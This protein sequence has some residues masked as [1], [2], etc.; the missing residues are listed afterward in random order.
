MKSWQNN[1]RFFSA[2]V[3]LFFFMERGMNTGSWLDMGMFL[4]NVMIAAV[5]LGLASCPQASVADYPDVVR[6]I[7]QIPQDHLVICGMSL[8][9][10]DDNNPVNQ[11]R[12]DR[13]KPEAFTRWYD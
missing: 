2:P 7:L 3:A 8:G 12:L 13:V 5:E 11:Y 9:F 4:Q 10:P 6:Q 1:Y